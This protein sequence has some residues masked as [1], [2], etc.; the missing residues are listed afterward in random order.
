M[1]IGKNLFRF[2]ISTGLPDSVYKLLQHVYGEE[3][4]QEHRFLCFWGILG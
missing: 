2:W 3:Q 4:Y 1:R